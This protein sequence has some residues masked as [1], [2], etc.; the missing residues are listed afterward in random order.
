DCDAIIV[1]DGAGPGRVTPVPG[2]VVT[3]VRRALEL[4]FGHAGNVAAERGFIF[5]RL[6]GQRVVVVADTEKAAEGEYGV[7]HLAAHL[8]DHDALDRTDL[9][10]VGAIDR[11]SLDLVAADQV[12]GFVR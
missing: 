12:A 11:G 7:G 3:V 2:I 9:V 5:Q 1:V 10:P 4:A 6:P 8:V